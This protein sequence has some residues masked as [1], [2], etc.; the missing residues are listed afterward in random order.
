MTTRAVPAPLR[1]AW[2][3]AAALAVIAGLL[4][5]HVLTSGHASHGAM[6]QRGASHTI[7]S[8]SAASHGKVPHADASPGADPQPAHAPAAA[9]VDTPDLASA[10]CG[11][12]CPGVKESGAPCV[13]S[14]PS[15]PLTIS[16]PQATLAVLPLQPA[17]GGPGPTYGYLPA[18]PTPCELS[19]SR[20]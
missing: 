11:G 14:A 7:A 8:H 17:G 1:R 9:A 3:F 16:P 18:G 20:T 10:A 4:G 5:M 2:L 19:I 13:P 6:S 15:G 12:S